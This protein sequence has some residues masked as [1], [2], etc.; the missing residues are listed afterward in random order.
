MNHRSGSN[1]RRSLAVPASRLQPLG[2]AGGE[3]SLGS[4]NGGAVSF[5]LGAAP[6]L[7]ALE[8]SRIGE[9]VPASTGIELKA[10]IHVKS[11]FVS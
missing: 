1:R 4:G 7:V 2:R 9:G 10:R 6:S 5:L 8:V 11:Q 3:R